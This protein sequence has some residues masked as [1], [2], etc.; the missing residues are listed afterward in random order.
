MLFL[1]PFHCNYKSKH[2]SLETIYP[3]LLKRCYRS[4]K[5][6]ECISYLKI[7]HCESLLP[8]KLNKS[9]WRNYDFSKSKFNFLTK[10]HQHSSYIIGVSLKSSKYSANCQL[11]S[12]NGLLLAISRT[13]LLLSMPI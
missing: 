11:L 9:S 4:S 12:Q 5:C 10:S 7:D 13:L 3:C 1:D 6:S 8:N 2:R